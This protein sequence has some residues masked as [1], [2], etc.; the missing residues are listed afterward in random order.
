MADPHET[1]LLDC[2]YPDDDMHVGLTLGSRYG[3]FHGAVGK[4]LL[5]GMDPSEADRIVR[6]GRIPRHTA[7]T[8][9][10]AAALLADI[11]Q[12]RRRG[13]ATSAREFKE[14]HAVAAPLLTRRAPR[15]R[16]LRRRV[17][18]TAS[19]RPFEILGRLLRGMARQVEAA[20]GATR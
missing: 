16:G 17:P 18:H 6:G 8:I 14:N 9:V 4:C 5:A 7:Q 13:W 10:D 2:A 11:D 20:T 1:V 15:A 19:R 12:V 3:V